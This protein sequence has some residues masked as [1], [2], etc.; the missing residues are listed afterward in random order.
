M[1]YLRVQA[2]DTS[3]GACPARVGDAFPDAPD[4]LAYQLIRVA[5]LIRTVRTTAPRAHWAV[6]GNAYPLLFNLC[7]EPIRISALAE[8]THLEVS[9]V[10][11][12]L[13]SLERDGIVQRIPDPDDRRAQWVT[14]TDEG[15]IALRALR[16]QRQ[17]WFTALL[18]DWDAAD[19]AR[20]IDLLTRFGDGIEA[21]RQHTDRHPVDHPR[22]E[23]DPA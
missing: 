21:Q 5:K 14:L 11:R 19:V 12:H 8:R 7:G 13:S 1:H 9:T 3:A 22:S 6:D 16:E 2:N 17:G 20:L 18:A 15:R 4:E 23:K 10:S